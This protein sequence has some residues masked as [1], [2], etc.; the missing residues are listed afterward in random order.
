MH[1]DILPQDVRHASRAFLRAPLF[2]L[3]AVSVLALGTGAATAVFSIVDRVLFR[4][5]PYPA[6]ERLI[7]LGMVAGVVQSQRPACEPAR[8]P[9]GGD[10]ALRIFGICIVLIN[11]ARTALVRLPY[12]VHR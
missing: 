3:A 4:S 6:G 7:S 2:T 11:R 8:A 9:G 5:L 12:P 10:I 1:L